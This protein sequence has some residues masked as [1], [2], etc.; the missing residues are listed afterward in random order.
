MRGSIFFGCHAINRCF[1]YFH[2]SYSRVGVYEFPAAIMFHDDIQCFPF[3][4]H[5][6]DES[7]LS[8]ANDALGF[9]TVTAGYFGML[10]YQ[11]VICAE[12]D[13]H[14]VVLRQ[15][16]DTAS[17]RAGM[18]IDNSLLIT[19]IHGYYVWIS[20]QIGDADK[21]DIATGDDL[22]HSLSVFYDNSFHFK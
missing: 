5:I 21:T 15:H 22:F 13:T 6:F 12:S 19:E 7:Y 14:M 1:P 4:V 8:T 20:F 17:G 18:Q 10:E 11:F 2:I 16:I 9:H 3:T